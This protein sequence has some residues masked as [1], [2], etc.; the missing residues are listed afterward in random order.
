LTIQILTSQA[1][2][3]I[4]ISNVYVACL[5]ILITFSGQHILGIS[6]AKDNNEPRQEFQKFNFV[7]AGDFGCGDEPN[8][9]I[10]GIVKKNPELTIALGDLSYEKSA[11]CWVNSVIPLETNGTVKIALGDHDLTNKMNK[12]ND[13]LQHFNM[14]KPYYSFN[15]QNVHFLAMTTA[16]NSII[17]Y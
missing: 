12:Y 14:T 17:P 11:L 9:T 1:I 13:Y 16:K 10:E 3:I 2:K 5:I 15:Y 4:L 7:A 8:R 6:Y